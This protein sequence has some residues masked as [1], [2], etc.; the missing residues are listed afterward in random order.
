LKPEPPAGGKFEHRKRWG[1]NFLTDTNL[2]RAIVRDS[3][4]TAED[5][6]L[7]IGAGA[8]ALTAE[9]CRAA[10][11]VCAYEIDTRL[12]LVLRDKLAEFDNADVRFEDF[13][14][15]DLSHL[16]QADSLR[17]VANLP[18]YITTPVLMRLL[19][20]DGLAVKS[21]TAMVQKE[22]A[23]RLAAAPGSKSYGLL[24]VSVG[25]FGVA[26]ITRT[27][28]RAMFTPRPDVDSAVVHIEA[29]RRYFPKSQAAF[30]KVARA[31]FAMRRKTLVNNLSAYLSLP[32][33]RALQAVEACGLSAN[34][35][36][37]QLSIEQMCQLSDL[38]FG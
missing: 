29:A 14:K 26:A 27:V 4:V 24:T 3:G 15:A 34:V 1:Q 38:L 20:E 22:V 5:T 21:V 19:E 18:Y 31:C 35:R 17:A 6:V 12:D 23:E 32:R 25:F 10:K 2:L 36:G 7:E 28:S 13:L 8:G 11:S 9:L 30:K 33:E 16:R 37:E